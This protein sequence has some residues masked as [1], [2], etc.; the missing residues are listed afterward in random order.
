MPSLVLIF[1]VLGTIFLGLATPTEA[2]AMGT[3]GA[4]VLAV[5]HHPEFSRCAQ[6]RRL[7]RRRR[8]DPALI[9]EPC[10]R[11]AAAARL[12]QPVRA[13]LFMVFYAGLAVVLCGGDPHHRAAQA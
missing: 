5:V 10:S 2:G 12:F 6:D 4:I 9:C 11:L 8:G 1:L 7:D 3:V 13:P